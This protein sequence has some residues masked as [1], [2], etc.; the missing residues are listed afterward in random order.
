MTN[1]AQLALFVSSYAPLFLVFGLLDTFGKGWPPRVCLLLAAVGV[2]ISAVVRL[3]TK[4]VAAQ[5]VLVRGAHARDGDSLAYIATYL[6]PF[7]AMAGTT[8]RQRV[9]IVVFFVLMAILYVRA[10]LFYV[11]PLFA[12]F[13]YRLFEVDTPA[14]GSL[15]L[16]TPRRFLAPDTSVTARRL[17]DYVYW[18]AKP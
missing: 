10:E 18:E 11:N 17:S 15:V 5:T 13:G 9:A 14:G 8:E 2:A 3:G 6:V 4:K 7:A 12:L 16:L 1:V